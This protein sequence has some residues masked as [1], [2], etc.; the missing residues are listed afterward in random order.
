MIFESS[1]Y[2]G[3]AHG[4]PLMTVLNE[5]IPDFRRKMQTRLRKQIVP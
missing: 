1:E 2:P 3:P 4:A 5:H